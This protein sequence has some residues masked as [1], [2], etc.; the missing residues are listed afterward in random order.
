VFSFYKY[1]DIVSTFYNSPVQNEPCASS[2]SISKYPLYKDDFGEREKFNFNFANFNL[3]YGMKRPL[4]DVCARNISVLIFIISNPENFYAREQLR[5]S[6][7]YDK[8]GL[9]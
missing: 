5:R 6:W 2:I 8:V 1:S 7:V 3:T 9:F 4:K